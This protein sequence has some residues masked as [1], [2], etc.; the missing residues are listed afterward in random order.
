MEVAPVVPGDHGGVTT[1]NRTPRVRCL[2]AEARHIARCVHRSVAVCASLESSGHE[3][4]RGQLESKVGRRRLTGASPRNLNVGPDED[5]PAEKCAGGDHDRTCGDP[6][7]I[8]GLY[9]QDRTVGR[10]KQ[11]L[12]GGRDDREARPCGEQRLNG[13]AV[14]ISITLRAGSPHRRS[15]SAVEH[16]ELD[17]RHVRGAAHDSAEGVD[18]AHDG[19][20]CDSA[21]CWVARHLADRG[22]ATGDQCRASRAGP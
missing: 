12:N 2:D 6:G 19:S 1:D 10:K 3:P 20:F 17:R 11:R 22:C 15:L 13:F 18:F 5:F 8:E 9:S 21:N 4:V 7:T 16:T 14:P